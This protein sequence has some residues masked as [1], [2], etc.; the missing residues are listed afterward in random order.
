MLRQ[1][2]VVKCRGSAEC[3]FDGRQEVARDRQE[4][5]GQDSAPKRSSK[6]T[7]FQL[8]SIS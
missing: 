8:V 4:G 5:S 7:L 6:V 3:T 1:Y 2:K